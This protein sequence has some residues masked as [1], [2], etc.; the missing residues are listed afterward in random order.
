MVVI[1]S[2]GSTR[3]LEYEFPEDRQRDLSPRVTEIVFREC[4][5][6]GKLLSIGVVQGLPP[7]L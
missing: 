2:Q 1:E 7:D 6:S 3:A 5:N 4:H